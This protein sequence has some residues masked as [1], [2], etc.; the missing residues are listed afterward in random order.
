[1]IPEPAWGLDFYDPEF[2]ADPYPALGRVREATPI[3]RDEETGQWMLTRFA[4]VYET[5]RDRPAG[6]RLPPPVQPRRTGTASAR[7]ALGGVPSARALVT[8]ELGTARPYPYPEA[9][10]QGVHFPLGDRAGTGDRRAV[11]GADRPLPG[12]GEVRPAGRL[13]QRY[14]VAV[15]GEVLGVP[16]AD[17][18]RLLDWSHAIVKRYELSASD[19]LKA[20]RRRGGGRVHRHTRAR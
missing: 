4:D 3:F 1:M 13:C 8:A 12:A 16:R 9:G 19:E 17:T 7:S 5:L 18:Q 15:V 14:S 2:L 10:L 11:A 20:R 6:P